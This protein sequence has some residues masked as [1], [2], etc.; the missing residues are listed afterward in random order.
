[1]NFTVRAGPLEAVM[2]ADP[3]PQLLD[4]RLGISLTEL[5]A[6][7]EIA[8]VSVE[9]MA[10]GQQLVGQLEKFLE[11]AVPSGEVQRL[12]KHR[13][14]IDHVVEGDPQLLLALADFVE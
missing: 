2:I 7:G 5:P 13:H 9:V 8:D 4:L 11:V 6:F 12:V 3:L 10:L 1:D 14:T